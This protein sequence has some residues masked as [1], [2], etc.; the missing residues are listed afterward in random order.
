MVK[1]HRALLYFQD[2]CNVALTAFWAKTWAPRGTTPK[3]RNSRAGDCVPAIAQ[4]LRLPPGE[5]VASAV[6]AVGRGVVDATPG[7]C[8]VD[9]AAHPA[10][11][12]LTRAF[13]ARSS[14]GQH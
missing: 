4:L 8:L 10:S 7:A 11:Q 5:G 13:L 6:W 3:E 12:R 9:W 1:K 14:A 2:E